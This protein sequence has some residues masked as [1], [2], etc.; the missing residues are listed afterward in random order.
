MLSPESPEDL[1]HGI[2]L[3]PSHDVISVNC[4]PAVFIHR[5]S[6]FFLDNKR[7]NTRC[8]LVVVVLVG[9]YAMDI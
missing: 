5:T 1:W 6:F 2:I 4:S 8:L 9:Y 3:L 7:Q